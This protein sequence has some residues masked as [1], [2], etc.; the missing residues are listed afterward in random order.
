MQSCRPRAGTTSLSAEAAMSYK[1]IL[2]HLDNSP[3]CAARTLL[4]AQWARLHGAQLVGLV[5]SG[6]QDGVIPADDLAIRGVDFIAESAEYLRRRAEA[7][8]RAF[9]GHIG[10]AGAVP[11]EVRLVDGT[12]IEAVVQHGR[13]S[14]LVVLGQHDGQD[15]LDTA[16]GDLAQRALMELGRPVLMVPFAGNFEGTTRHAVVAWNASREAGVALRA[17]L[18]A[19]QRAAKVTLITWRRARREGAAT[20]ELLVREMLQYLRR[21]GIE[22]S[23]E[24]DVTEIEVGDSLLSRISDLGADLLVMGGYGHSRFRE[25]VLGG[26]TRQ[27]L[28]QMTV[29]VLMAH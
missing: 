11:H 18:P 10:G 24:D 1:T 2:V 15:D 9:Y 25:L 23:A 17:A 13:T 27:I 29:P 7:I 5:P 22:A 3:R 28:A 8:S 20:D 26:A 16:P 14:D 19:L 21:H 12:A 4:A 6:L